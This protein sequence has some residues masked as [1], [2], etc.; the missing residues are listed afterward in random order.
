LPT[1]QLPFLV[2]DKARATEIKS[3]IHLTNRIM[4]SKPKKQ[5]TITE[6]NHNS[7]IKKKQKETGKNSHL[8]HQMLY[9]E[10]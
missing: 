2:F 9:G 6:N 10:L 8:N 3:L 4:A 5:P 1:Q 7:Q